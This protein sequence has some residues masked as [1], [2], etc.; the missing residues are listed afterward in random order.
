MLRAKLTAES[1]AAQWRVARVLCSLCVGIHL[2]TA[3][4]EALQEGPAALSRPGLALH[5]Q[6]VYQ[7]RHQGARVSASEAGIQVKLDACKH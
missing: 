4:S 7:Q 6:Q 3:R 1:L 5:T 2:H